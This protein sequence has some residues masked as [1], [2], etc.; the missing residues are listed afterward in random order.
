MHDFESIQITKVAF[1][2][3]IKSKHL[4][5]LKNIDFFSHLKTKKL[6]V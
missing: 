3:A 4:Q 6:N 1:P 5:K 2:V